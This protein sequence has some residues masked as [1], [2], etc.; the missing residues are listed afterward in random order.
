MKLYEILQ[1]NKLLYTDNPGGG[2]L[3]NQRARANKSTGFASGAMTGSIGLMRGKVEIKTDYIKNLRGVNGEHNFRYSSEK[4]HDLMKIVKEEGWK[5]DA[6]M[7]WVDYQGIAKIA[8]G[9]HRMAVADTLGIEWIPA[10]I[11]YYAG[12]EEMPGP[13]NPDT[14]IKKGIVGPITQ[15]PQ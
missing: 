1:E 13:F 2:W 15:S 3:E 12:G 10:D 8:E 6:I 7:I 11:R 5:P 4:F 9:N 14:L